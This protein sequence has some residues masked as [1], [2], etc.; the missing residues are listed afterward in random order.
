MS[1]LSWLYI[2]AL[3]VVLLF[4]SAEVDA[5]YYGVD[6]E[7]TGGSVLEARVSKSLMNYTDS[8][9]L[10]A[11]KKGGDYADYEGLLE[12][13]SQYCDANG[14]CQ[15]PRVVE[16]RN[17][18]LKNGKYYEKLLN[19][20]PG[21]YK[22]Q[23]RP[24]GGQWRGENY[25]WSNQIA[26]FVGRDEFL[27][28]TE[29]ER[30]H[31]GLFDAGKFWNLEK[32]Y[33]AL[34]RGINYDWDPVKT[35]RT[36]FSVEKT[37]VCG[38]DTYT[39]Y[40]TKETPA[41]YW[42]PE[43]SH[44]FWKK[45]HNNKFDLVNFKKDAGWHDEYLTAIGERKPYFVAGGILNPQQAFARGLPNHF[46]MHVGSL[47][48]TS[49]LGTSDKFPGYAL[50]P[51]Y[52]ASGY[53]INVLQRNVAANP[54]TQMN[55]PYKTS[56]PYNSSY[57]IAQE[58]KVYCEWFKGN[59]FKDP[60]GRP[61]DEMW[62]A[63]IDFYDS[64]EL[65]GNENEPTKLADGKKVMRV[66]YYEAVSDF[67]TTKDPGRDG[68]ARE[69]WYFVKDLGLVKITQKP[70][71]SSKNNP[72]GPCKGNPECFGS[73]I[74]KFTMNKPG[75]VLTRYSIL[76]RIAGDANGDAAVDNQ[77]AA[78]IFTKYGSS[79]GSTNSVMSGSADDNLIS[80]ADFNG[81]KKVNSFD[82]VSMLE[83]FRK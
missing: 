53:G 2:A 68:F 30:E 21:I 42:G 43:G 31:L 50:S 76:E 35:F 32:G 37:N 18:Q 20:T 7:V 34:F 28:K 6:G 78:Y 62:S 15:T 8:Y 25:S 52:V 70:W 3:A 75:V 54:V 67:K 1:K 13:K 73:H 33:P 57:N 41:A 55:I 24:K 22:A 44:G 9:I 4:T 36:Y 66:R 11:F 14:N 49:F 40:I 71:S 39:M 80:I 45:D 19:F 29:A 83:N 16:W 27:S 59:N 74:D 64:K 46:M 63:A 26:L 10:Y 61:V 56:E 81:D 51:R 5:A 69:D 72:N 60:A 38:E 17:R 58:E 82:F 12:V 77:D 47:A 65:T 23:F 79:N 48:N